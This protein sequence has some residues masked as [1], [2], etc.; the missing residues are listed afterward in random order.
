MPYRHKFA[1]YQNQKYTLYDG[2]ATIT[3]I[4][5]KEPYGETY[6]KIQKNIYLKR[7]SVTNPRGIVTLSLMI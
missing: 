5:H 4:S 3:L 7:Y 1:N 2:F 6:S